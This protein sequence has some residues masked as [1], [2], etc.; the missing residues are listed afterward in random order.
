MTTTPNHAQE[1][2]QRAGASIVPSGWPCCDLFKLFPEGARW[3]FYE[4]AKQ[5]RAFL[6]QR[7]WIFE[8]SH[9]QYVRRACEEL[10]L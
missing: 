4:W 3:Q 2:H 8:E 10:Q 5:Q 6:E 1:L 7:G 9:D